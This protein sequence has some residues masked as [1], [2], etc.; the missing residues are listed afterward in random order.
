MTAP[1]DYP[2]YYWPG[3]P[4]DRPP[5]YWPET[6][7]TL[8]LPVVDVPSATITNSDALRARARHRAAQRSRS[9]ARW[10]LLAQVLSYLCFAG[11]L[12][13]LV[14]F[15]VGAILLAVSVADRDGA[16]PAPE[17]TTVA[18]LTLPS[19]PS[20]A[21]PLLGGVALDTTTTAP[22]ATAR[23]TQRP[24]TT[25][26]TPAAVHE[27]PAPTTTSPPAAGTTTATVTAPPATEPATTATS[28][29]STAPPP[30]P[31]PTDP[32]PPTDLSTTSTTT[33][34]ATTATA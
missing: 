5:R 19:M 28:P 20:T 7:P 22:A 33:E 27:A 23:A 26:T 17:P 24:T 4:R 18:S 12:V 16:I 3:D 31:A 32:P 15:A 14:G 10:D 29:S 25:N 9:Q 21:Y 1:A 11:I 34:P 13:C 30:T 2:N 6:E 8:R